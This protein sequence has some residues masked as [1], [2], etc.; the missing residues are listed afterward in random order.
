LIRRALEIS[1]EDGYIT[2]SLGWVYYKMAEMHFK[3][4]RKEEALKLLDRAH[5]QLMQAAELTGGDSVV[6]EHLGDV[7]SL[8]GDKEGALRRYEEAVGLEVRESEQPMLLEKL[9]R[10]RDDLG[11][12]PTTGEAP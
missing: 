8:R 1:P 2:D 3:E 11:L 6:S 5:G 10:L 7:L 4:S 12:I 9:D